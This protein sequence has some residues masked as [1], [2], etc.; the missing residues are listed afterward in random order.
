MKKATDDHKEAK[1]YTV[2]YNGKIVKVCI[3]GRE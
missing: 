3:P 1:F 2:E